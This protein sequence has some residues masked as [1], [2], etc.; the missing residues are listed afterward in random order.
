MVIP[1]ADSKSR[2][3]LFIV[4]LMVSMTWSAAINGITANFEQNSELSDNSTFEANAGCD[5]FTRGAGTPIYVDPINGS[6]AW[7]GTIN[8][9]KNSL[10]EAVIAGLKNYLIT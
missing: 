5:T 2:T 4:F 6:A 8:C 1:S 9:P 7:S 10:S 3:S